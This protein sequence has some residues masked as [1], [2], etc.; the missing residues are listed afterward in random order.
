MIVYRILSFIVNLF[1]GFAAIVTVFALLFLLQD[2]TALLQVFLMAGVVLYGWF[3]NKFYVYVLTGKQKMTKKQKDWLQVNAIV[4]FIFSILG[5]ANCVYLIN[6]PHAFDD[7]IK[8]MRLENVNSL[9][10]IV[11]AATAFLILCI[12]LFIHIVW[13]YIL[14]K[15]YKASFAE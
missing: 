1:C 4:A 12:I 14:M 3:A 2:P 6:D 7:V 5:I 9:E 15:K 8:N 13:T 11:N 10:V